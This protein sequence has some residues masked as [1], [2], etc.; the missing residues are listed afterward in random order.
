MM[1]FMLFWTWAK[2]PKLVFL[3]T[4]FTHPP[5]DQRQE[6]RFDGANR[7]NLR[8][9]IV[10]GEKGVVTLPSRGHLQSITP[11]AEELDDSVTIQEQYYYFARDRTVHDQEEDRRELVRI[12]TCAVFHKFAAGKGVPHSFVGFIRQWPAL[13]QV[14]VSLRSFRHRT[15]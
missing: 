1:V 8:H 7:R 11:D 14:V 15:Y 4:P 10:A 2:V 13:P 12:P 9:F 5:L 3:F 6:D